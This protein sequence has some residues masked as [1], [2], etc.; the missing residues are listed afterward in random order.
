MSNYSAVC[1]ARPSPSLLRCSTL[2]SRHPLHWYVTS[3]SGRPLVCVTCVRTRL[4]V[5]RATLLA[6]VLQE[7]LTEI[8]NILRDDYTVRR[9]MLIKRLDVTVQSFLWSPR[10]EV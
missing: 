10:A 2:P 7:M 1:R 4:G 6:C 9:E 3:T 5:L 8:N